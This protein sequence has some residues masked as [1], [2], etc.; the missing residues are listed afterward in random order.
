MYTRT[1]SAL[2]LSSI[3]KKQIS[4]LWNPLIPRG[5]LTLLAG[6]PGTGKTTLALHLAATLSRGD[7]L[8]HRSPS[9]SEGSSPSR[10]H[11]TPP[12][13]AATDPQSEP[14]IENRKSKIENPQATLLLSPDD[15]AADTLHPRLEQFNANLDHIHILP[16]LH[17]LIPPKNTNKEKTSP[18]PLEQLDQVLASIP[19]LA[20]LI[21]DPITHYLGQNDRLL[22][23]DRAPGTSAPAPFLPPR[24]AQL[25]EKHNT[26]PSSLTVLHPPQQNNST[27]PT[28]PPTSNASSAASTSHSTARSV[29]LL[30]PLPTEAQA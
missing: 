24:L 10:T 11:G 23:H 12:A 17:S 2:P 14:S 1:L 9:V 19:N 26:S 22:H 27:P 16:N 13:Q 15:N 25:A 7:E 18:S 28:P 3:P 4:W 20:L 5:K 29:L 8:P 21:I 6:D 30:T